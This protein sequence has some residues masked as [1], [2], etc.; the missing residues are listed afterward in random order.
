M[1]WLPRPSDTALL[2]CVLTDSDAQ[3]DV[4]VT[5][6]YNFYFL[7]PCAPPLTSIKGS[8]GRSLQ[9]LDIL[10]IERHSKG[11]GS[12]TIPRPVCNP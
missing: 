1:Q 9:G 6:H 10:Q 3:R 5:K 8:G 12:D 11:L 2:K 7:S 4:P